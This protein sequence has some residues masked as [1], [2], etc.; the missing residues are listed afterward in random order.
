MLPPTSTPCWAHKALF[1]KLQKQG[2]NHIFGVAASPAMRPT[3]GTYYPEYDL[4]YIECLNETS[5]LSAAL[6]MARMT[7][8]PSVVVLP[9]SQNAAAYVAALGKA[10]SGNVR[11]LMLDYPPTPEQVLSEPLLGCGCS[12]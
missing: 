6:D 11:L 8:R 4:T 2:I 10:A 3:E 9:Y 1:T 5:V 7:G 12:L